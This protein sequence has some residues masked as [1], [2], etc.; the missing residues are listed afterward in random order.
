MA[1]NL[2]KFFNETAN[3]RVTIYASR[4]A[5]VH[6]TGGSTWTSITVTA[7]RPTAPADDFRADPLWTPTVQDRKRTSAQLKRRIQDEQS[8]EDALRRP[9]PAPPPPQ[10]PAE[11]PY[12]PEPPFPPARFLKY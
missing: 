4:S 3:A 11:A 5:Q 8:H 10:A 7:A 12:M 2:T 1:K 6:I 9:R